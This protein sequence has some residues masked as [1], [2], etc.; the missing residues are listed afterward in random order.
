MG[1]CRS[2][3]SRLEVSDQLHAPGDRDP[4]TQCIG[5]WVGPTTCLEEVRGEKSCPYRGSNSDHLTVQP[6]A[7]RYT[8]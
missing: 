2:L 6:I 1:K 4:G 8:D 7:S 3:Y 5:V